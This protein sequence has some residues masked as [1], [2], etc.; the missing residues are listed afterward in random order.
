MSWNLISKGLKQL[1]NEFHK[2]VGQKEYSGRQYA[3]EHFE[4]WPSLI[5]YDDVGNSPYFTDQMFDI[6]NYSLSDHL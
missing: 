3:I 4:K 2:R 5:E 6:F 1:N